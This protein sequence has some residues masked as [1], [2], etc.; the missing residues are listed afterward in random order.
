M[1]AASNVE[2]SIQYE[3]NLQCKIIL[4]ERR[5]WW[6]CRAKLPSI[7]T[8]RRR[9]Q[10]ETTQNRHSSE[11]DLNSTL[12]RSRHGA[13]SGRPNQEATDQV[14]KAGAPQTAAWAQCLHLACHRI[15]GM[16]SNGPF[17]RRLG[18]AGRLGAQH[19]HLRPAGGRCA[20][21]G[22]GRHPA[23]RRP[24]LRIQQSQV[25]WACCMLCSGD[26][27]GCWPLSAA[28]PCVARRRA[29]PLNKFKLA[30]G[31]DLSCSDPATA[32]TAACRPSPARIL[33]QSSC[34]EEAHLL[35][36]GSLAD[37]CV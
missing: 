17:L 31:I 26:I 11:G 22:H 27:S 6:W 1:S 29:T 5:P 9:L 18:G 2:R 20:A 4:L 37:L 34:S 28:A 19:Q 8:R 14:C 7:N 13:E 23:R 33:L 24:A 36:W 35:T 3:V 30:V 16:G 15:P 32:S 25:P 12:A 10:H 21:G